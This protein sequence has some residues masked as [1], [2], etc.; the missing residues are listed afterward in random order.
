MAAQGYKVGQAKTFGRVFA[1]R[2]KR[3][4]EQFVASKVSKLRGMENSGD[5][6]G[7]TP[8]VGRYS[9][10]DKRRV[11]K[12]NNTE[13]KKVESTLHQWGQTRGNSAKPVKAIKIKEVKNQQF[14][15][16]TSSSRAKTRR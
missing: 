13:I 14:L 9:D 6:F 11:L 4:S 1:A 5:F 3:R 16:E 2:E 8:G 12:T 10:M 15:R 7:S